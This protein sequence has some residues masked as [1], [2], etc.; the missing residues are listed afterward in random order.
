M[1]DTN[2]VFFLTTELKLFY[3]KAVTVENMYNSALPQ[4][5][6]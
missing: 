1:F 3:E 6:C 5:K 2:F 4:L